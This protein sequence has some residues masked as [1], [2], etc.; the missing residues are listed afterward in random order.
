[1]THAWFNCGAGVAGDMI[2]GALVDAGADPLFIGDVLGGLNVDDYALTFERTQRCGIA[3]TRALVA[4]HDHDH[5]HA[6]TT[7]HHR[8]WRDIRALITSSAIPSDIAEQALSIFEQLAIVEARIHGVAVDDVE[9]HEVGS[10]DAIVDIV[11]ICAA[12]ASLDIDHVT[13]SPIAVGHGLV[14]TEH[15]QL[16]NP[17]PAVAHLFADNRVPVVGLDDDRELSTPT[18]VAAMVALADAF[19]PM[20]DLTPNAVGYGAGARDRPG[21]ANVVA[22]VIGD[23]AG[24]SLV[25]GHGQTVQLFE[26]NVDDVSSEVVAYTIARLLDAGAHDA[27]VTPIIMKKGRPAFTV[28]VLC[29]V[30]RR[31]AIAEILI[32]ETG[33]LGVRAT[34]IERWPQQRTESAVM[35]DGHEIRVKITAGRIKVEFDDAAKAALAL[36]VPVREIIARTQHAAM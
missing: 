11:G 30:A 21:R 28:H 34:S 14:T 18:G 36:G 24:P 8:P 13:C 1:M 16:P 26:T 25:P 10:T 6:S 20:P 12:L 4:V 2:L 23:V 33:T 3:C 9:F 29:D 19:G 27:W 17:A 15:G 31:D 5:E 32:R 22:V 35:I 7:H